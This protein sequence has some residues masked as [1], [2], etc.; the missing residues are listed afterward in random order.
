MGYRSRVYLKTTTEG[1]ILL[2]QFDKKIDDLEA[3]PLAYADIYKTPDGFYKIEYEDVKWYEEYKQVQS[4]KKALEFLKEK[5][6]PYS[7][8]RLG[9]D[10][11]DIE[12][13][14]NY[15]DTGEMPDEIETF[16]PISDINDDN[17]DYEEMKDEEEGE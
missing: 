4:F 8:I 16:E 11:E 9:E 2:K 10:V 5:D 7:Y 14:A 17:Y 15:P 6:I 1:Y 13:E 3:K 12:H